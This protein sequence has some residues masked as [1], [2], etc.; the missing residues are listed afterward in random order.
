MRRARAVN[1]VPSWADRKA[2]R[3]VYAACPPGMEV[4]HIVP[5]RSPVVTGLHV[6]WNLQYLTRSENAR[7]GRK[8]ECA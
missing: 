2:I 7:K 3:A 6:P 1:A 5:L 4:D 8:L